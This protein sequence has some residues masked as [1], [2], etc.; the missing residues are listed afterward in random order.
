[1][2][3]KF[4]MKNHVN[5]V[6]TCLEARLSQPQRAEKQLE[7]GLLQ[8][9]HVFCTAFRKALNPNTLH[10][11]S[12]LLNKWR[13]H[14]TQFLSSWMLHLRA[15]FGPQQVVCHHFLIL[16]RTHLY[17]KIMTV[18]WKMPEYSAL[19][20]LNKYWF[21]LEQLTNY[22]PSLK[23]ELLSCE[24]IGYTYSGFSHSEK[25]LCLDDNVSTIVLD[26]RQALF[27]PD[28]WAIEPTG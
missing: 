1:M 7:R 8:T 19:H 23:C 12:T 20:E 27:L 5:K 10:R 9:V 24:V 13:G 28:L 21:S 16:F 11:F 2:G 3:D 22:T 14:S 4:T 17:L 18:N 6:V 25:I 15:Q 26:P